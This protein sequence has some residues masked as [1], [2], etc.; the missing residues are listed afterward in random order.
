MAYERTLDDES[1]RVRRCAAPTIAAVAS[2]DPTALG[3]LERLLG[4]VEV[5]EGRANDD[6]R[7]HGAGV[8]GA[9]CTLRS[10]VESDGT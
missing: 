6:P 1:A 7:N 9:A 4:R 3:S 10:L 8:E 5:I 2:A